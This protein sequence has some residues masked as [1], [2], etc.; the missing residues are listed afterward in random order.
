ML[1]IL[2]LS[3]ILTLIIIVLFKIN[4]LNHQIILTLSL[5]IFMI[6][7]K[8]IFG[9]M[10]VHNKKNDIVENKYE[11]NNDNNIKNIISC[12]SCSNNSCNCNGNCNG[13][14][15]SNLDMEVKSNVNKFDLKNLDYI[16]NDL[17]KITNNTNTNTNTKTNNPKKIDRIN[18]K[19]NNY[20]FSK[21][22][23]NKDFHYIDLHNKIY[24]EKKNISEEESLL[25]DN[26]DCS[27]DNSC[28][29][30]QSIYNFHKF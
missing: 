13:N 19:N 12:N 5:L 11:V 14:C 1:L 20:I 21:D 9:N 30:K 28:V 25:L 27:N 6:L 29:I 17:K 15:N 8:I 16:V 24:D 22:S 18:V 10:I 2:N 4:N 7:F 26:L 23:G 3:I